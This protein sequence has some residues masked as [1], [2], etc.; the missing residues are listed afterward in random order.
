MTRSKLILALAEAIWFIANALH[1]AKKSIQLL[2]RPVIR[3]TAAGTIILLVLFCGLL[4]SSPALHQFF[5]PD[6]NNEQHQCAITIFAHG[7][8]DLTDGSP[9]LAA[10]ILRE[11]QAAALFESAILSSSDYLLLPGRAPP[12]LAS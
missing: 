1:I 7:H 12:L 6:A 10:P 8:V 4:S 5:H 3:W 2:R 9:V 11:F